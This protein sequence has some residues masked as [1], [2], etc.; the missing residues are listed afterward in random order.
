VHDANLASTDPDLFLSKSGQ[1]TNKEKGSRQKVS[2]KEL[3]FKF[4]AR[5]LI[6]LR[7]PVNKVSTEKAHDVDNGKETVIIVIT[8]SNMRKMLSEVICFL[9]AFITNPGS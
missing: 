7:E 8:K 5:F 6:E 9:G 3:P 4:S 2:V 1:S